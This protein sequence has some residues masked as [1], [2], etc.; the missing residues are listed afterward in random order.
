VAGLSLITAAV[1]HWDT[2]NLDRALRSLLIRTGPVEAVFQ[3]KN[4]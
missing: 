1:V 4:A 2:V 3:Q